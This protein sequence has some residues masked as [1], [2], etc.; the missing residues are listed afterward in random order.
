MLA[1]ISG[2]GSLRGEAAKKTDVPRSSDDKCG[3]VANVTKYACK[4]S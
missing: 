3:I 1:P 2:T 4:S